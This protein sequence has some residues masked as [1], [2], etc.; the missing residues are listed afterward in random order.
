MAGRRAL[1]P[2]NVLRGMAKVVNEHGVSFRGHLD[3]SGGFTFTLAPK[4]VDE[5][6]HNSDDFD[7]RL[8]RF[9]G[10]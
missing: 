9:A 7:E 6:E 1:L 8:A 5:P 3:D 2:L 10:R 4:F